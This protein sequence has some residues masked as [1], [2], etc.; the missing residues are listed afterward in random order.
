M[1]ALRNE[2]EWVQ[3]T[4]IQTT[5]AICSAVGEALARVHG[6]VVKQPLPASFVAAVQAVDEQNGRSATE[7]RFK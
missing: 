3:D 5:R 7:R 6:D 4:D 2:R 1:A